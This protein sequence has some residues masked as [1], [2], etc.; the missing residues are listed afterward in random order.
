MQENY[1]LR[2][3]KEKDIEAVF[4]LFNE[5]YVRDNSINKSKIT[6][7][8]HVKWFRSVINS[9]DNIFFVVTDYQDQFLGQIRY[10]VENHS[11]IVSIGLC[12][13]IRGKG[14]AKKLLMDSIKLIAEE[15]DG[16]NNVIAYILEQNVASQKVFEQVD[17][18]L[19]ENQ[20][21]LLKYIY[22]ITRE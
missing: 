1:Y 6:W 3:V 20:R 19:S 11:A 7:E 5:D 13:E 8:D 18:V 14:L 15:N 10:K 21:G 17:F 16:V 4:N 9:T 12:Q 22:K 2:K